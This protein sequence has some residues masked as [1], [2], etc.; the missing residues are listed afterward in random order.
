MLSQGHR[1]HVALP[2]L[3]TSCELTHLPQLSPFLC[4]PDTQYIPS[5][6]LP[7]DL[8][9]ECSYTLNYTNGLELPGFLWSTSCLYAEGTLTG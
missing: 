8:C 5:G 7:Q 4:P 9:T 3:L 1:Q 6:I 2:M